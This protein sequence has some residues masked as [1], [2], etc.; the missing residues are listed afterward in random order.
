MTSHSVNMFVESSSSC[1]VA[2]CSQNSLENDISC[3]SAACGSGT[4]ENTEY[5]LVPYRPSPVLSVF[6]EMERSFT[7]AG[8]EWT[9]HQQ[10]NDVGLASVVWEAVSTVCTVCVLF[11]VT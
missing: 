5:Q 8:K 3:S 10:W 1:D 7:F 2:S 6:H 9:I 11:C 4:G